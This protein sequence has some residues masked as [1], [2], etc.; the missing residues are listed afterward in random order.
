VVQT[1]VQKVRRVV[2]AT[3]YVRNQRVGTHFRIPSNDPQFITI[4]FTIT[5][6]SPIALLDSSKTD[7]AEIEEGTPEDA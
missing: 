4:V 5:S 7:D 1:F 2:A 3:P 6:F